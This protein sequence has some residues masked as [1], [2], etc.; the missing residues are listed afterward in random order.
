MYV[1]RNGTKSE[2]C[3]TVRAA[4][5]DATERRWAAIMEAANQ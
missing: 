5:G 4:E 3:A 2:E 1:F